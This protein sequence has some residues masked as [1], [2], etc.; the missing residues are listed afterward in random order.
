M[1]I[2]SHASKRIRN[3]FTSDGIKHHSNN[4][5]YKRSWVKSEIRQLVQATLL[6]EQPSVWYAALQAWL[7]SLQ[8]AEGTGASPTQ[9]RPTP[10]PKAT[11]RLGWGGT[12][13]PAC[14]TLIW[15][16][17]STSQV[18]SQVGPRQEGRIFPPALPSSLIWVCS[19]ALEWASEPRGQFL[20]KT[21]TAQD[22][23][24]KL[25]RYTEQNG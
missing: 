7:P 11:D 23:I 14:S 1:F 3:E 22:C 5:Y 21:N 20:L 16:C 19:A 18:P 8:Q 13:R 2:S 24:Q 12:Q 25:G 17:T 15:G 4:F 6:E 10:Q 9:A